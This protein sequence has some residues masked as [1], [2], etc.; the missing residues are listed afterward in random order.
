MM[1]PTHLMLSLSLLFFPIFN[2]LTLPLFS[3]KP[4][5]YKLLHPLQIASRLPRRVSSSHH[6]RLSHVPAV[7][8]WFSL[9]NKISSTLNEIPLVLDFLFLSY[10]CQVSGIVNY[11]K[12]MIR[13]NIF[14]VFDD[15]VS[16]I[17]D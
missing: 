6:H 16:G 3:L 5:L 9:D 2:A 15:F 8:F 11:L 12:N 13:K 4:N 10:F 14:W 1:I 17:H 7:Y